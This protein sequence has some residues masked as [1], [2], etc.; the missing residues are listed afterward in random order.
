MYRNEVIA[1][2]TIQ[3]RLSPPP[4]LCIFPNPFL[5]LSPISQVIIKSKVKSERNNDM[6]A[7]A[8]ILFQPHALEG[9]RPTAV[10]F[11]L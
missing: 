11:Q 9:L 2:N 6:Q 10:H 3:C 8:K 1:W 7:Q 5:V 4:L